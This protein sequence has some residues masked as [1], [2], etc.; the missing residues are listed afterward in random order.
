MLR[1]WSSETI[2]VWLELSTVNT[3]NLHKQDW[4]ERLFLFG[5]RFYGNCQIQ[6]APIAAS[7]DGLQSGLVR[8]GWMMIW[9]RFRGSMVVCYWNIFY[10]ER[11]KLENK[12]CRENAHNRIKDYQRSRQATNRQPVFECFY[13]ENSFLFV[14]WSTVLLV[15]S[16]STSLPFLRLSSA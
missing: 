14:F 13:F 12:T 10:L 2:F 4:I 3:T 7:V 11:C 6:L 16:T 8:K 1:L 9:A 15:L 5:L